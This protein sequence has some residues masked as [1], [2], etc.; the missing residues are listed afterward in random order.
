MADDLVLISRGSDGLQK[1][2]D[3]LKLFRESRQLIVNTE[4]KEIC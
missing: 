1:G 2:L 3:A 4:K